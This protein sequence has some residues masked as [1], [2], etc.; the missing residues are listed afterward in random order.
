MGLFD[1]IEIDS[2]LIP[3]ISKGEG[4]GVVKIDGLGKCSARLESDEIVLTTYDG[5]RQVPVK[6]S[7]INLLSYDKGNF[8]NE[9][10]M[11]IGVSGRQYVLAG[12]NNNDAELERFYNTILDLKDREHRSKQGKQQTNPNNHKGMPHPNPNITNPNK[13]PNKQQVTTQNMDYEQPQQQDTYKNEDNFTTSESIPEN[14]S[15]KDPVDEIR[16]YYELKEDGIISED[17]FNQKKKQLLGL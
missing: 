1:S 3:Y 7:S 6:L 2:R 11:T 5:Q 9:P 14:I 12:V 13:Q 10:K 8:I 15:Q 4:V 17:E 16:R